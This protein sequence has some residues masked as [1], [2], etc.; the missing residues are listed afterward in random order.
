MTSEEATALG[1]RVV[2]ASPFE[3]GLMKGDKGLRTWFCQD[4]QH[5]LPALDH[6]KIM[7]CIAWREAADA[8][9]KV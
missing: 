5:R 8:I 2:K 6:P 4:F 7:E 1:Y 9:S 3:V